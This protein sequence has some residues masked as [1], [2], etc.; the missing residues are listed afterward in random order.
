MY[1]FRVYADRIFTEAYGLV[2]CDTI[3]Q[4]IDIIQ[5]AKHISVVNLY[6]TL[7]INWKS[8][9]VSLVLLPLRYGNK[10]IIRDNISECHRW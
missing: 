5:F 7:G 6:P 9:L 4:F 10:D 3:P 8:R 2:M 1:V